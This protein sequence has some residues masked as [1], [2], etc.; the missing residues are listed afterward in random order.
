MSLREI[1]SYVTDHGRV[2][3]MDLCLRFD[4]APDAMRPML[5]RL[6]AKG[7][8]ERYFTT[9]RCNHCGSAGNCATSEIY[10]AAKEPPTTT[11]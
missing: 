1:Q 9:G 4:S 6:I 8:I 3:L 5:A 11:T 7:R 2:T 10:S